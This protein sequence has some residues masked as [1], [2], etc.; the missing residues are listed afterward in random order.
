MLDPRNTGSASCDTDCD[1]YGNVCDGDFD[2]KASVSS[3]D[4]STYFVPS[5]VTGIPSPRGTD[6]NCDGT[7]NSADFNKFFVPSFMHGHAP[8]PSGLT[9]AGQPGCGCRAD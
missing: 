8:S 1:G 5:F 3:V 6:M 9:C 7:V 4:F 2:Q